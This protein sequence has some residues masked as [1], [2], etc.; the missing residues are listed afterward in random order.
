MIVNVKP[1]HVIELHE[2]LCNIPFETATL[3]D[4]KPPTERHLAVESI[5]D[6]LEEYM[7][8]NS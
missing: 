4:T 6:E 7:K 1:E 2:I 8:Y 3:H 5:I